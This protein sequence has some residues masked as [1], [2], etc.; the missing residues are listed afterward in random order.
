[1]TRYIDFTHLPIAKDIKKI[2]DETKPPTTFRYTGTI[3]TTKKNVPVYRIMSVDTVRN[4]MN[5][6]SDEIHVMI[7]IKMKDY[8]RDVYP[9][10]DNLEF[11]FDI[12]ELHITEYAEEIIVDRYK[13]RFKAITKDKVNTNPVNLKAEK[14]DDSELENV[15]FMEVRLQLL[16]RALEPIRIKLVDGIVNEV[17]PKD[18]V[19]NILMSETKKILIDGKP[20]L[21][22]VDIVEPSNQEIQYNIIIPSGTHLID[23]PDLVQNEYCGMYN[24][25]MGNYIQYYEKEQVWFIHSLYDHTQFDKT[26]NKKIVFYNTDKQFLPASEVTYREEGKTIYV[27]IT[28]KVNY[29]SDLEGE[30]MNTG[31]GFKAPGAKSFMRKPV[32]LTKEKVLGNRER[33]NHEVIVKDREDGLNYAPRY[34]EYI[35]SNPFKAYSEMASRSVA[36][37]TFEWNHCP[38]GMIYPGMPCKYVFIA[39]GQ[40]KEVKGTILNVHTMIA[41]KGN[42]GTSNMY[43]TNTV[44]TVA[45][46]K[47]LKPLKGDEDDK[48]PETYSV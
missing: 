17:T 38:Y 26:K 33:L 19:E 22:R 3:H 21:D 43:T 20:S 47:A 44:I 9:Y 27:I 11:T 31:V 15:G 13:E 24:A 1:M 5:N 23:I 14:H 41:L 28:G 35:T 7:Y 45:L 34:K 42:P 4:Y 36:Q 8:L 46:E 30:Y 10:A 39:N 16:N 48:E 37:I 12:E 32:E 2:L 6:I 40:V 18:I 25:G 29:H